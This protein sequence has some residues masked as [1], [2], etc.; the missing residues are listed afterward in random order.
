VDGIVSRAPSA[1]HPS[2]EKTL[3]AGPCGVSSRR[4]GGAR[5]APWLIVPAPGAWN[6]YAPLYVLGFAL[7]ALWVDRAARSRG[8]SAADTGAI[9]LAVAV[10]ALYGSKLGVAPAAY[11]LLDPSAILEA[12]VGRTWLGGLAGGVLLGVLTAR[13]LGL[14]DAT[15]VFAPVVPLALAIGRLGCLV[16]GCCT[17][18]PT[19]APWGIA[20]AA[21]SDPWWHAV[22]AG[23]LHASASHTGSVHPAPLYEVAAA[24]ILMGWLWATRGDRRWDGRRLPVVL[25]GYLAARFGVEWVRVGAEPLYGLKPGQWT[26]LALLP[27]VPLARDRVGRPEQGHGGAAW[28]M[29]AALGFAA[30]PLWGDVERIALVGITLATGLAGLLARRPA[31]AG[32]LGSAAIVALAADDPRQGPP[33]GDLPTHDAGAIPEWTVEVGGMGGEYVQTCGG[34]H[35]YTAGGVGV[36]Y[37]EPLGPD[38]DWSAGVQFASG[39]DDGPA[40]VDETGEVVGDGRDRLWMAMPRAELE[41]RWIGAGLGFTFGQLRF[42]G[43]AAGMQLSRNSTIGILPGGKLRLGPRDLVWVEGRVWFH[44]PAPSPSPVIEVGVGVALERTLPSHWSTVRFGIADSGFFVSPTL[45]LKNGLEIEPFASV[46]DLD[47]WQLALNVRFH[48]GA[49]PRAPGAPL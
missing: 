48:L 17:G 20:Y 16:G 1:V 44:D 42:D 40:E 36:S 32:A 15:D 27:F 31:A 34:P 29:L 46:G 2:A 23:T 9:V 8:W 7:S 49:V 26:A 35:R 25:A 28:A 19:D 47:T 21:G 45:P 6:D 33:Y 11:G 5:L 39:V 3:R 30:W 13:Q 18:L 10:G 24:A 37:R 14:R 43:G 12:S 38:A 41:T 4:D 22:E